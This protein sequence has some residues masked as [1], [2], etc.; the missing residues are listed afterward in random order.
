MKSNNKLENDAVPIYIPVE[1]TEEINEIIR[2][3]LNY[4]KLPKGK[5]MSIS[6]WWDAENDFLE[7]EIKRLKERKQ[8]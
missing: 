1:Y 5:R 4:V 7:E 6:S 8:E 2:V 3:G